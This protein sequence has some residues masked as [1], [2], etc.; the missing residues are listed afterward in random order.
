M[1]TI[2]FNFSLNINMS[3]KSKAKKAQPISAEPINFYELE[4]VQKFTQKS[5]NPNYDIHNISVPFRGAVIGSSGAGKTNFLLN[6]I[7]VMGGTFNHIYVY[8]QAQEP[9]YDY[10]QSRIPDEMLTVSYGIE[11]LESF[12][13]DNYY[14]QSLVIFD[15]L[16][17]E[18][19]KKQK[20]ICELFIRGRKIKGGVS[21]LYLSQS[22]YKIPKLVRLQCNYIFILKVPSKR[23][24]RLILSEYALNATIEQ[25]EQMYKQCCMTGKI[26]S[27]LTIDMHAPQDSGKTFRHNFANFISM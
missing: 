13:E 21:L 10:L 3:K 17:N 5:I 15:D 20:C 11:S 12:D 2:L 25:L 1:K 27:F 16:C 8:T 23:D 26:E 4:S 18:S 14:G 24:L 22:Y 6:L 19:A 7:S 9:L